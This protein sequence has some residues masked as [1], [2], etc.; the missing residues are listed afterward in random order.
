[1]GNTVFQSGSII[2]AEQKHLT[3]KSRKTYPVGYSSEPKIS[4]RKP[5]WLSSLNYYLLTTGIMLVSFFIIWGAFHVV[6]EEMALM[7]AGIAAGLIL[8]SAVVLREFVFKRTYRKNLFAQK[9]LDHN[10]K[11]VQPTNRRTD[12]NRLTLEKNA[13]I[14]KEI[15]NRSKNAQS[16]GKLPELH[17]EVFEMCHEYLRKS[18]RE[19][20]GILKES[21]RYAA[22]KRGQQKMRR[23]HQIHLLSWA[24]LESQLFVQTAKVQAATNDKIENAQRALSVLDTALQFYPDDKNLLQSSEAIKEFI[25]SIRVSHWIE[26]AE[27]AAFKENYQRAVNHYR[28]ALFF[29]ARENE[30]T[31]E[32]EILA[33]KINAKIEE[34]REKNKKR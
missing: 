5:F 17:L 15:E 20:E 23:L 3:R 2:S 6:E 9:R 19:L 32:R 7:T 22:L 16:I 24:S 30:R 29:L 27:R 33:E 14:I 26:Q 10:L 21:P 4:L 34:L 8:I 12:E 25:V 28:D 31:P 13:A 1:L 18:S 11:S